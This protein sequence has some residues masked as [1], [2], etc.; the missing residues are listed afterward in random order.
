MFNDLV[1][2]NTESAESGVSSETEDVVHIDDII[3]ESTY[4]TIHPQNL[5]IDYY[6]TDNLRIYLEKE[7][8]SVT[9]WSND[10]LFNASTDK[11]NNEI[12]DITKYVGNSKY[13]EK[14]QREFQD[15]F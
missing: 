10:L 1:L 6:N 4:G 7:F 15:L 14:R 5:V 12:M 8:F 11:V 13:K 9:E 2:D 3:E